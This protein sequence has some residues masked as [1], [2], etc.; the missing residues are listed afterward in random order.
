MYLLLSN[1]CLSVNTLFTSNTVPD[2]N[3]TSA[4]CEEA[5]DFSIN[6]PFLPYTL[7]NTLSK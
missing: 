2:L 4:S 7:N 6:L 1:G 5:D 3:K